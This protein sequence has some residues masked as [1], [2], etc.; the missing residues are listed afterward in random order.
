MNTGR[1]TLRAFLTDHNLEQII[2]PEIQRDYV[3]KEENVTKLLT[4]I[5]DNAATQKENSGGAD[6]EALNALSPALRDAVMRELE[7]NNIYSNIGFIYAYYDPDFAGRFM[8]IDGQ[9]RMTT[10]FLVLLCL[11]AKEKKEDE[12]RRLYLKHGILKFD[13]KVRE[14]SHDFMCNLVEH[15]LRGESITSVTDQ[16]WFFSEYRYDVTIQSVLG[17]YKVIDDFLNVSNLPIDYIESSIEFWYF[18]TS[19]SQQ[20]EELYIYMNSRGESVSPSENIK[21]ELLKGLSDSQKHNW[22]EK[23]E[24][25]Q[26]LFWKNKKL[27]V[28]ADKGLEEFLKWIKI[29]EITKS[30][31][32]KSVENK[33][34][35]IRAIKE[36]GRI[37]DQG[38]TLSIIEKYFAALE[39]LLKY[40]N[41]LN[42]N[43]DWLTGNLYAID[44]L[45]LLP[46][47]MYIERQ[48]DFNQKQMERFARFFYNLSRL[49]SVSKSPF[50][51]LSN[52]IFMTQQFLEEG[53]SDIVD[54]TT[55]KN[56]NA[57]ENFVTVDE[58]LKLRIYKNN[59]P[60]L[61]V[62]IENA[63]WE[64]E[65]FK[66]CDGKISFIWN[67]IE[68]GEDPQLFNEQ[69]LNDF[70]YCLTNFKSLFQTP[71]NTLRRALLTKGDYSSH[72]GRTATLNG[73]R[74]S[75]IGE[76]WRWKQQFAGS[77]KRLEPYKLL[78]NDFGRI[79]S[80][81]SK[82]S[83]NEVLDNIITSFLQSC[84]NKD[85]AYYFVKE[86]K[87]LDYCRQKFVCFQTTDLQE[88]YLLETK[89]AMTHNFCKLSE[90]ITF[91]N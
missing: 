15:V 72:D 79:K 87:I 44:Y 60:E 25:W 36:K 73:D 32:E 18:D 84:K 4:S 62:M 74:Y 81:N 16:Y 48:A 46:L 13:Y 52:A 51:S 66:L 19:E 30:N 76:D 40:Q 64:A 58:F 14:A 56:I 78:L 1:Y 11:Y 34:E 17:N 10:L 67:C 3:W 50:E 31:A 83:Q 71:T 42:F 65:D 24:K 33:A 88:I 82:F 59:A 28:N 8:L 27:N 75:F 53:H 7:K 43:P 77:K 80:L 12:F 91:E 63:F 45:K 38:L 68:Y 39:T 26:D 41:Q 35:N 49:P 22:G 47:L 55:L 21:A 2:I 85:W 61:R 5:A 23:W 20:G 89:N 37:S 57:F 70:T 54:L 9:Q 29:I 6:S 86:A 69:K 90:Y